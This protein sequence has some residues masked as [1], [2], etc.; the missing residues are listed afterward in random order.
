MKRSRPSL[1][2]RCCPTRRPVS[3]A[4]SRRAPITTGSGAPM[5]PPTAPSARCNSTRARPRW[6]SRPSRRRNST[7]PHPTSAAGCPML[8]PNPERNRNV[9]CTGCGSRY[10]VEP[11]ACQ[12]GARTFAA[13]RPKSCG[14]LA[15]VTGKGFGSIKMEGLEWL[16]LEYL[17]FNMR[18]VD[19]T[20]I[21]NVL[22]SDNPGEFAARRYQAVARNVC[23][24]IAHLNGR[25]AACMG[26]LE[27]FPGNW[28]I[29]S[30]GTDAYIRV[31][32]TFWPK[33]RLMEAFGRD[34]GMHRL[35]CKSR[36]D[37]LGAHRG[38]YLMGLYP[39]C[40]LPR[41][42]RDG[43]DYIQFGR[44]W[45]PQDNSTVTIGNTGVIRAP[46]HGRHQ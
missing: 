15:T 2:T 18:P 19:R 4:T 46:G 13:A 41:Y 11:D 21:Y 42:S 3:A 7:R 14:W 24:W 37:H 23:G 45:P 20:E 39:E 34:R 29:Y 35:E 16:A 27:N 38:L 32:A 25:P 44:T 9:F 17:C 1:P 8:A 10:E 31:V 22:A 36:A 30:F 28:Q 5:A 40:T 12:C 33:L 26:I 6:R 43:A